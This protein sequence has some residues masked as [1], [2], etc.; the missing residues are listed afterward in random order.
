MFSVD[1]L[2]SDTLGVPTLACERNGVFEVNCFPGRML[3]R[4]MPS[5]LEN[6]LKVHGL[7]IRTLQK[8][9]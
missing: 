3:E 1:Y 6:E 7:E 5:V 2:N 8:M 9:P 4:L